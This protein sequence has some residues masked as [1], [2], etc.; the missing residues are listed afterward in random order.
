MPLLD[1]F[2]PPL[3]ERRHWH[4]FHNAWATYLCSQ[5]NSF[6][7]VGYFAEPN[8]KFGIEIDVA[9]FDETSVTVDTSTWLPPPPTATG[10]LAIPV[11]VVEVE[12]YSRFGGP[13]LAGAIGLISPANKDRP[14]NRDAL[15]SKCSALIQTGVGVVLVDVVT[16]RPGDI[17]AELL[18]R[19]GSK[20][21]SDPQTLFAAAY[22]PVE[23]DGAPQLDYWYER[24]RI[25]AA[26]PTLPLWLRGDVCVPVNLQSTYDQ[27]CRELRVNVVAA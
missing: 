13:R 22:R 21:D 16:E 26:L 19:L 2:R 18:D 11:D 24:L 12:S 15:V 20:A 17:H 23:R 8:V 7:P 14:A 5:I 9:T 27:T 6:L 25:G 3:S 4:G 1:H 10:D